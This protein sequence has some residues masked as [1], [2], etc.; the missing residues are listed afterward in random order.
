MH[1]VGSRWPASPPV[2]ASCLQVFLANPEIPLSREEI[3]EAMDVLGEGTDPAE[4]R[5]ID[6]W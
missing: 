2:S 6:I 3:A 5:A 4:G 1:R